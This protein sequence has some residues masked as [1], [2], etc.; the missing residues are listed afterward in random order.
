MTIKV[1]NPAV[2]G[3]SLSLSE[4]QDEFGGTN[5]IGLDE[6]Y[7]GGARVPN[8]NTD[9]PTSGPISVRNFY[10]ATRR[11]AIPLNIPAGDYA[12]D[13]FNNRGSSYVAGLSDITVT[14]PSGVYVGALATNGYA[15]L[16]PNSFN[17]AD[18]VTIVN[19]GVISGR[20]GNGGDSQFGAQ[21]GGNPG[22]TAGHALWVNRPTNIQNNGII[23]GGGGGGGGGSGWTPHKGPT[24]WGGGGGGGG[25]LLSGQ[26]GQGPYPGNSG[27]FATGA[28]GAGGPGDYQGINGG[29]GGGWG[30][31]GVP[32]MATGG[33]NPR[34]GG[35]AGAAGFYIVGGWNVT[36]LSNGTRLGP[37][38]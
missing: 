36:W 34:P 15:M 8:N 16:V 13:V 27:N 11:I 22:T 6:Y 25:G 18:T 7:R 2:N 14:V 37:A 23:A 33:H 30:A 3:P 12:Y 17:P 10:G 24:G 21:S 35:N 29:P 38:G 28:G 1:F 26:G 32:G 31:D 4:I 19:N 5:P 20:G 9:V